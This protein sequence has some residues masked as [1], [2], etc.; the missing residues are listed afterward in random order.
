MNADADGSAWRLA[1]GFAR[2]GKMAA[3]FALC[4]TMP[5]LLPAAGETRTEMIR[6]PAGLIETSFAGPRP[7]GPTSLA[8]PGYALICHPHPLMGG[9]LS[10][11]V[12]YTLA[13]CSQK[14]G[15]YALRFNF[16]GEIGRAHV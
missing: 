12:V 9:A 5:D 6:G 7:V 3:P 14:A 8:E 13:S 1:S 2:S 10:T 15:L 4:T 16:I 11:K